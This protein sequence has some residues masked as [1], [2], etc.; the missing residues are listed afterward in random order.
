MANIISPNFYEPVF[1]VGSII[2]P[3]LAPN[4]PIHK[5]A[6]TSTSTS[7]TLSFSV[8]IAKYFIYLF[9]STGIHIEKT[10][11]GEEYKK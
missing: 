11:I 8:N 10:S 9:L 2:T 7:T 5:L 1:E 6:N 3:T 4:T